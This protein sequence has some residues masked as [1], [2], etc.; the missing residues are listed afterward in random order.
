MTESGGHKSNR[1]LSVQHF[2]KITKKRRLD[3]WW[4]LVFRISSCSA[5]CVPW[6]DCLNS[7]GRTLAILPNTCRLSFRGPWLEHFELPEDNTDFLV[8]EEGSSSF[9]C[10]KVHI[11]IHLNRYGMVAHELD[12]LWRNTEGNAEPHLLG[13]AR[14]EADGDEDEAFRKG[15]VEEGV[16]VGV[17]HREV[18]MPGFIG[19]ID[20]GNLWEFRNVVTG[21]DHVQ[22]VE[23]VPA[24]TRL[25][26]PMRAY[27]HVPPVWMRG[28]ERACE[29]RFVLHDSGHW[30]TRD[31]TIPVEENPSSVCAMSFPR[32]TAEDIV[33]FAPVLVVKTRLKEDC[34][35]HLKDKC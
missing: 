8:P 1:F 14:V 31:R 11:A 12:L 25:G 30:S 17:I 34:W 29:E 32:W 28:A 10:Q 23:T 7:E 5:V 6:V 4:F 19:S 20:H 15:M 3:Y 26:K 18:E 9:I 27:T 13:V 33:S 16:D 21:D 2:P 35:A 22:L 24:A